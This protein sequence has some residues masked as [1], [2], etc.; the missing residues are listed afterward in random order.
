[1]NLRRK[2]LSAALAVGAATAMIVPLQAAVAQSSPPD[3]YFNFSVGPQATILTKGAGLRVPVSVTCFPETFN[4]GMSIFVTQRVGGGRIASGSAFVDGSLNCD[5]FPHVVTTT[6]IA[7]QNAFKTGTA[8]STADA[9][10]CTPLQCNSF[11]EQKEIT[12]KK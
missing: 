5:G 2:Y 11:Q 10:A 1:M 12:I 8:L 7:N 4:F 9:F 3:P 6:L